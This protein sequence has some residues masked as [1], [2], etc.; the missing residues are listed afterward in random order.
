MTWP[1][2]SDY[3]DRDDTEAL[4]GLLAAG[5]TMVVAKSV[6]GFDGF[7]AFSAG[8]VVGGLVWF[9]VPRTTTEKATEAT[10]G[11]KVAPSVVNPG[12]LPNPDTVSIPQTVAEMFPPDEESSSE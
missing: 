12:K 8:L 9:L 11:Q 7:W 3:D 6:F 2:P 5:V 4:L 1:N 10:Y